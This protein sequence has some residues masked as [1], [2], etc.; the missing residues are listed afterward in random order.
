[1]RGDGPGAQLTFQKPGPVL[2]VVLIG[3]FV[4]WL[5]SA[6]VMN[7]SG[8]PSDA[9]FWFTGNTQAIAHGEV[10]RLLTAALLHVPTGTIGHIL[11]ALL[12]LYFLGAALETSFGSRRF[13][14]FLLSAA[15]L[16]YGTQFVVTWAL[17]PAPSP[18]LAPE[19]YFGAMPVVEA[20]AIAWACSFRGRTVNLFFVLPVSTGMLIAFVVGTSLMY[21]IAGATPPS[22]HV[23]LFA[24]MGW[25]YLLGGGS[26]SPLRKF[27][28][29][30][31]LARLEAETKSEGQS[32]KKRAKASGLRVISGGRDPKDGKDPKRMLH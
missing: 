27:Y 14:R 1:M 5:V 31:R 19:E 30:Y 6:L 10:W 26:P 16:S 22:G 8:F 11:S 4:I 28:L 13:A 21:L 7:W 9:F 20:V 25:G 23:A 18:R 15:V 12:G 32:R 17:G 2:R 29:R 3:L 24:G